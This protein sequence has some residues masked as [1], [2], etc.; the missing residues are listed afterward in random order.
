MVESLESVAGSQSP[1]MGGREG[2]DSEGFGDVGFEP[3]GE[4]GCGLVV[5]D[6]R[7]LESPIGFGSIVRVEYPSHVFGGVCLHRELWDVSEGVLDG[8]ELAPLPGHTWHG[9]LPG[10]LEA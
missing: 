6:D 7:S 9:R 8:V 2:E 10:G 4:V 3:A 1:P 5:A